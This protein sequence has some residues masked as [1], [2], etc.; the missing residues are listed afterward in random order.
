MEDGAYT[1]PST[2]NGN[3]ITFFFT[4]GSSKIIIDSF[5]HNND[6]SFIEVFLCNMW[7]I[8]CRNLAKW[9]GAGKTIEIQ[10]TVK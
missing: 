5:L 3:L 1:L 4:V 8:C 9:L 10:F 7:L 2:T 6:L